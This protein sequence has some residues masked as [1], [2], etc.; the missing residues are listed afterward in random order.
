MSGPFKSAGNLLLILEEKRLNMPLAFALVLL[1]N[2]GLI[3]ISVNSPQ[4]ACMAGILMGVISF[5]GFVWLGIKEPKKLAILATVIFLIMVPAYSVMYT[6]ALYSVQYPDSIDSEHYVVSEVNVEP[7]IG[8][9]SRQSFNFSA[10]VPGQAS[11]ITI[12]LKVMSGIDMNKQ[13]YEGWMERYNGTNETTFYSEVQLDRGTYIFSIYVYNNSKLVN[14]TGSF[15]FFGPQNIEKNSFMLVSLPYSALH[16]F[17][18]IGGLTYILIGMY[19][20]TKVARRQKKEALTVRKEEGEY[21]KCPVCERPI[22]YGTRTCPYCGAELEYDEEDGKDIVDDDTISSDKE[23]P[24]ISSVD[25]EPPESGE[26][27]SPK[28]ED[29]IEPSSESSVKAVEA[30]NEGAGGKDAGDSR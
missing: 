27:E 21:I 19:W 13:Y 29:T 11:N 3:W 10:V 1:T 24:E 12:R 15:F 9:N 7:Y 20:W 18:Q 4:D 30:Q 23:G 2:L 16:I 28:N 22:P 8:G 6:D 25:E 26:S 5:F 14:N 17:L